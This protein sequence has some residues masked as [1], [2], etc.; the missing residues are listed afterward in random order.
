MHAYI[1]GRQLG[2]AKSVP[3]RQVIAHFDGEK[4]DL[5]VCDGAP[6]GALLLLGPGRLF[7]LPQ[8]CF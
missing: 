5:V 6:D 1:H 4:A 7:V 2:P 3:W 8:A